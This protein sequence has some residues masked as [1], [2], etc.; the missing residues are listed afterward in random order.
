MSR[1]QLKGIEFFSVSSHIFSEREIEVL[2]AR[3]GNNGFMVYFFLMCEAFKNNYYIKVDDD[4]YWLFAKKIDVTENFIRQVLK[5]LCERSMFDNTLFITDNVL[6]SSK[7]QQNYQLAVK[8]RAKKT[9]ILIEK[10]WLL[11]E[12]ETASYIKVT[13]FL[14]TSTKKDDI[15]TKKDDISTNYDTNKSK[16]NKNK[17]EDIFTPPTLQQVTG[18]CKERK[19]NVNP[20]AFFDFYSAGDWKD[21]KGNTV[22]SWKQKILT[23][24]KYEKSENLTN[25]KNASALDNLNDFDKGVI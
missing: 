22:K 3:H 10:Y 17:K 16:Q 23:W 15:S 1:T 18:Y 13:N 24:E 14:N 21:S 6:T 2:R 7:I 9:N 19:N 25:S 4:F 12:E 5:F 11:S 20:Q 8:T